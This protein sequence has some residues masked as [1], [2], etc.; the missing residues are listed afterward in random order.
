MRSRVLRVCGLG[1]GG[2]DGGVGDKERGMEGEGDGRERVKGRCI[3][4]RLYFTLLY[5]L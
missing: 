1:Y 5:L 3:A 4:R 2:V